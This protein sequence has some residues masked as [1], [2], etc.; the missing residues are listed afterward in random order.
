MPTEEKRIRRALMQAAETIAA[1]EDFTALDLD[2]VAAV[3]EVAPEKLQEH[4]QDDGQL[5]F[6]LAINV[7]SQCRDEALQMEGTTIE[8]LTYYATGGMQIMVD[9]SLEFVKTWITDMVDETHKRGRDRLIWGWNTI[10]EIIRQGVATGALKED[11][12][13]ARMTGLMIAEYYGI[14]FLWSVLQGSLNAVEAIRIFCSETFP[15]FLRPYI[16]P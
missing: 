14:L 11:T 3:A 10:A 9:S 12:P 15:K 13:V 16:N 1:D 7:L 4:V 2:E 5:A 6:D 8:K